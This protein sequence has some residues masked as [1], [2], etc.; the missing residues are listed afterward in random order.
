M[1]FWIGHNLKERLIDKNLD[2]KAWLIPTKFKIMEF[3]SAADFTV[4]KIADINEN[5]FVSYSG[6]VD[7]EYALLSFYRNKIPITPIL[8]Q[9]TGNKS[10]LSYAYYMCKKLNIQPI[11]INISHEEYK[12]LYK[13]CLN[14]LHAYGL[15]TLPNILASRVAKNKNGILVTGNEMVDYNF[16]NVWNVMCAEYDFY[17]EVLLPENQH[18]D[19]FTHTPEIA[20]SLIYQYDGSPVDQLKHRVYQTDYRPKLSPVHSER[21]HEQ[22]NKMRDEVTNKFPNQIHNFGHRDQFI[23]IMESWNDQL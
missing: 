7:S 3:H 21:F 22:I 4:K 8:I 6:G 10:E 2:F 20:Y 18:A 13:Y 17:H 15:W 16:D 11:V 9:T 12:L 1:S 23:K 19:F 14:K 5:I